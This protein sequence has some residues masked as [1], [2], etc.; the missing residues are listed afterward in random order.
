MDLLF[1]TDEYVLIDAT[2]DRVRSIAKTL[3]SM[4]D[5]IVRIDGYTD[6]RGVPTTY[7]TCWLLAACRKVVSALPRTGSRLLPMR[8][9]T[10]MPWS[11]RSV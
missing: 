2:S 4:D 1:R 5:I 11:A 7:G 8:V 6:E 9:P 10:A 3:A